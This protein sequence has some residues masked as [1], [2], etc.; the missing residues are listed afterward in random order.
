MRYSP[1]GGASYLFDKV[2]TVCF[3]VASTDYRVGRAA[4]SARWPFFERSVRRGMPKAICTT[5]V[6]A[7]RLGCGVSH[8]AYL[9]TGRA[10]SPSHL[11]RLLL[12]PGPI[13]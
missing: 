10:V 6:A 5:H 11:A 9:T 8:P 2:L 12:C 1:I 4:T 3:A 13:L 7:Y